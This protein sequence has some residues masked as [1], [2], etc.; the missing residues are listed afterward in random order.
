MSQKKYTALLSRTGMLRVPKELLP[1]EDT[2]K[3][4]SFTLRAHHSGKT[5]VLFPFYGNK[6][7]GTGMKRKGSLSNPQAKSPWVSV[8]SALRF[9]EVE[10]PQKSKEFPITR[11][12]D[13]S[14]MVELG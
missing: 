2:G 13:G 10:P 12:R 14:L 7:N 4:L 11:Q 8:L 1:V 6:K 5:L 9:L 3:P